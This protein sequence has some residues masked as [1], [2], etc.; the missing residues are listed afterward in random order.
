[1]LKAHQDK[2]VPVIVR[3]NLAELIQTVDGLW[4]VLPTIPAEFPATVSALAAELKYFRRAIVQVGAHSEVWGLPPIWGTHVQCVRKLMQHKGILTFT[5][6]PFYKTVVP[7]LNSAKQH[8]EY[9]GT[10]VRK[11]TRFFDDCLVLLG[12]AAVD[13]AQ[14][15]Y[16]PIRT[17][18]RT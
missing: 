18:C 12:S 8:F 15:S 6:A 9:G 5:C 1:M 3:W 11:F 10:L 16:L 14:V 13:S 7:R 17:T 4:H 2:S